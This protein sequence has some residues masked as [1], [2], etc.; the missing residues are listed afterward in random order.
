MK[1]TAN[2]RNQATAAGGWLPP[3]AAARPAPDFS[4]WLTRAARG[5]TWNGAG[6][7][8]GNPRHEHIRRPH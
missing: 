8:R 1:P 6:V 2:Y 5:H 3:Q 7:S 4:H